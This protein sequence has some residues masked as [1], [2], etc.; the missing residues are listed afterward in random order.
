MMV[1]LMLMLPRVPPHG[2]AARHTV[3]QV[4][5]DDEHRYRDADRDVERADDEYR[6]GH[7]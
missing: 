4:L 6:V 2:V 1:M 7:C 5:L 3:P